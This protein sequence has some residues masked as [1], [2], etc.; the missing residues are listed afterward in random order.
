MTLALLFPPGLLGGYRNQVLRFIAFVVHASEQNVSQLLLPSLLWSTQIYDP[1]NNNSGG[2]DGQWFPIPFSWLFD[3]DYWNTHSDHLPILVNHSRLQAFP[4]DCWMEPSEF[5]SIFHVYNETNIIESNPRT[6][7]HVFYYN[8]CSPQS[9]PN[10]GT[11]CTVVLNHLQRAALLQGVIRPLAL[12][13]SIPVLTGERLVN[14]RAIDFA[15]FTKNCTNPLVYGGGRKSGILWNSYLSYKRRHSDVS[16]V[17]KLSIATDAWIYRA[18]RPAEVWRNV[19]K[20]CIAKHAPSGEYIA[21]HARLELEMMGHPCGADM[22]K[23][24]TRILEYIHDLYVEQ[25]ASF[26]TLG[27][28]IA[29]SR[30]G[31]EERGSRLYSLFRSYADENLLTLNRITEEPLRSLINQTNVGMLQAFECGEKAL[32]QYYSL[33]PSTPDHG[34]LLQSV[35]NFYIAVSSKIFIGVA[36]SSYSTDILTTRF[37]LGKGSSN[38][39]YTQNGIARVEKDGLP[40]PHSNCN[41]KQKSE[42]RLKKF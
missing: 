33:N 24:L 32:R 35:I 11:G 4:A 17:S 16:N 9:N 28:F 14:P 12:N 31:M 6:N 40:L 7:A 8:F 3:V 21:L 20:Q 38:Y 25:N 26:K 36:G 19:A 22:E 34:S 37:W 10:V 18:L 42:N 2:N 27:L 29:V 5:D 30:S 39:R 41:R 1:R 23:N 13:V 15:P